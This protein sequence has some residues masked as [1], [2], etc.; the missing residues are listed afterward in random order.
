M[1]IN[2]YQLAKRAS[3]FTNI[4]DAARLFVILCKTH[5]LSEVSQSFHF[6]FTYKTLKK[7]NCFVQAIWDRSYG[8]SRWNAQGTLAIMD[9]Y[10]DQ[11]GKHV[12]R[13][14]GPNVL[15]DESQPLSFLD[16]RSKI[17]SH[18]GYTSDNEKLNGFLSRNWFKL[19]LICI[20]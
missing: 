12:H 14:L 13:N 9:V 1:N 11:D 18:K 4:H 5:R 16:L 10:C 15:Q 6:I 17:T 19:F 8:L 7:L 2:M 3:R 20:L